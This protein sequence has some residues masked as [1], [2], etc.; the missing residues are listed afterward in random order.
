MQRA[1]RRRTTWSDT[2]PALND[3]LAALGQTAQ[4]PLAAGESAATAFLGPTAELLARELDERWQAGIA[5]PWRERH[6]QRQQEQRELAELDAA[7]AGEPG[8]D[9]AA[10]WRQAVLTETVI[11]SA[12]ALPLFQA[13]AARYPDAAEARYAIGQILLQQG[14]EAGLALIAEVMRED[15]K[16][17][18]PGADL[19]YAFLIERGRETEAQPY[20]DAWRERDE[21]ERRAQAERSMFRPTDQYLAHGLDEDAVAPLRAGCASLGWVGKAW[22]VKKRVELFPEQPAWLLLVKP[23]WYRYVRSGKAEAALRQAL[24]LSDGL[25]VAVYASE[26]KGLFKKARKTAGS[27]IYRA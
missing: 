20:V 12:A 22:L 14:D 6:Q 27:E 7:A 8:L 19:A 15:P 3:R 11:D 26:L 21:L 4:V 23:R 2:H 25:T 16:A 13:F 5:V 17:I 18:K 10:G 9:R 24:D 1:L